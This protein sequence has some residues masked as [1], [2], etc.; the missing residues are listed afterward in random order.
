MK[1]MQEVKDYTEANRALWDEW[2]DIHFASPFYDVEGFR[3]GRSTLGQYEIAGVGNVSGK[4]LLHLQCHFGL[5]TLSWARL[6]AQVTG[7]DFSPKAISIA[8]SLSTDL[9]IPASFVESNI[10]DLPNVLYEQYDII[11]ASYG[12]LLWLSDLMSWG[13][14]ICRYLKKGGIFFIVDAH[15]MIWVFDNE[16][17]SGLQVK[18]SYFHSFH[19]LIFDSPN[20]AASSNDKTYVQYYW[21]HSVSDI[22]NSLTKYNLRI[23]Y[24][25]EHPTITWKAFP[26]LVKGDDGYFRLPTAMPQI[27]LTFS[28]KA[29]Q[30]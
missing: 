14:I 15:P 30:E 27:P 2:A 4:T 21:I 8:R 10:Y 24:F 26:F 12:A 11:F 19:P 22:I 23:E 17:S 9:N 20:Y 25:R 3:Q 5:D 13:Q 7:V 18:H 29:K 16:T 6:G 28:L 1:D